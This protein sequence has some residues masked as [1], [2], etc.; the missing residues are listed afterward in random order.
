MIG[1]GGTK[2]R[3]LASMEKEQKKEDESEQKKKE[4]KGK[5]TKRTAPGTRVT[6]ASKDEDTLKALKESKAITVYAAASALGVKASVAVST[7]REL[8]SKGLIQKVGGF[9][10]HYVYRV[11]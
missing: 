10:G 8:E 6:F 9:S 5:Q 7:L 1:M 2:K 11:I 4:Q 3:P